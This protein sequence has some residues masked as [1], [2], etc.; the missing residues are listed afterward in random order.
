MSKEPE[1]W[2][3]LRTYFIEA[4]GALIEVRSDS[5]SGVSPNYRRYRLSPRQLQFAGTSAKFNAIE[6]LDST[7]LTMG[8][9]RLPEPITQ[10]NP[11]MSSIL[12]S[13]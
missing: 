2:A 6:F 4:A 9:T 10:E 8:L 13:G 12:R 1:G 7:R 11:R 3:G 5:E